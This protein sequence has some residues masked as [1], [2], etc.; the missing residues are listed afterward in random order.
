VELP[1]PPEEAT[2]SLEKTR[3]A[4]SVNFP[5]QI[6]LILGGVILVMLGQL[7]RSKAYTEAVEL[8]PLLMTA[9]GI[10]FFFLGL[11]EKATWAGAG[12]FSAILGR[13]GRQT[14]YNPVQTMFLLL[15]PAC[16][17]VVLNAAGMNGKM[18]DPLTAVGSWVMAIA[19]IFL[20]SWKAGWK[21]PAVPWQALAWAAALFV[22]ALPLRAVDTAHFPVQ[23]SGDEAS[24]GLGAVAF[25][26][27]GWNNIFTIN[28]FSFPALFFLLPAAFIQLLGNSTEALRLPAALGGSLTVAAVYLL[29]RQLYN[30]RTGLF[31]A[32]LLAGLHFH[33]HFSRLGLNNIWDGLFFVLV[34]LAFWRGWQT[35]RRRLLLLAGLLLGLSQYFYVTTRVLPLLMLL[36]IA[37]LGWRD[38]AAFK[39]LRSSLVLMFWM[40]VVVFAPLAWFFMYHPAE[41]MAPL[42]RVSLFSGVDFATM[43]FG[44]WYSFL[45]NFLSQV[46]NGF[47][48]FTDLATRAWYTSGS[49]VLRPFYA[50]FFILGIFLLLRQWKDNRT[51]LL[52]SWLACIGL[53][54]GLSESTPAAQRYVAAAPAAALVAGFCLAEIAGLLTK[55]WP[56]RQRWIFSGVLALVVTFAL[57]DINFYFNEYTPQSLT[58]DRNTRTA[59]KL[60]DYMHNKQGNWQVLF[61]GWPTMGYYS[62]ASLPYLEP[63]IIGTEAI[64]PWGSPENPLPSAENVIFVFLPLHAADLDGA[65]RQYPGGRERDIV[66]PTMGQLFT[67]YELSPFRQSP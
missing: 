40:F 36:W 18:K 13:L 29:G 30:H 55:A 64:H 3:T 23:L 33:I 54:G 6:A 2:G 57:S 48:G 22:L 27:G 17:V 12:K 28:W 20:S 56:T 16:L 14:R 47:R 60:A 67:L 21:F 42:Q 41:Y 11:H 9:L 34:P 31:A 7:L 35:G 53:V 50:A 1:A 62:I 10:L 45:T 58:F 26:K 49:P 59:Q 61:Y 51:W 5:D 24:V 19:F 66:D 46:L 15:S 39:R 52:L 25:L 44:E 32:L 38:R 63:Q 4:G 8:L 65:L 37:F 43:G